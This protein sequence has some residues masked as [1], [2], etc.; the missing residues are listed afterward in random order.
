MLD[1]FNNMHVLDTKIVDGNITYKDVSQ[2]MKL[3]NGWKITINSLLQLSDEIQTPGYALCMYRLNQ[4]GLEN[5]FGIFRKQNG[6]NVNP[7]PI[8]FHW[9]FK[10]M[11]LL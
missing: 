7:T 2:R 3:I 5:L 8:Q 10:I 6:N 4:K 9:E 11:F 1:I